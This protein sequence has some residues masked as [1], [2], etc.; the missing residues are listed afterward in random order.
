MM[1]VV[2]KRNEKVAVIH[3][4]TPVIIHVYIF[5][6]TEDGLELEPSWRVD[7]YIACHLLLVSPVACES[8]YNM[9]YRLRFV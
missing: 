2:W 5:F 4:S 6:Q 3:F 1:V 8:G 9:D 7:N